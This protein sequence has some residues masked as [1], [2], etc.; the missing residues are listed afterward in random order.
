MFYF[1]KEFVKGIVLRGVDTDLT[2]NIEGSIFYNKTD[3]KFRAYINNSVQDLL[4]SGSG[5]GG[6]VNTDLSNLTSPTAIPSGVNLTSNA[7][8]VTS[9]S[10]N[11]KNTTSTKSADI[12]I[13]SGDTTSGNSGSVILAAGTTTTGQRGSISVAGSNISISTPPLLNALT[14]G[15]LGTAAGKDFIVRPE[16][17]NASQ[18]YI[19]AQMGNIFNN[20]PIPSLWVGARN[21]PNGNSNIGQ[22]WT[23]NGSGGL[24]SFRGSSV[25]ATVDGDFKGSDVSLRTFADDALN[26]TAT[27]YQ[28]SS[29]DLFIESSNGAVKGTGANANSGNIT[30]RTG[31][32]VGSGARGVVNIQAAYL[33]MEGSEIYN[34]FALNFGNPSVNGTFRI[35]SNGTNLISER[36]E[37]GIWIF[38]QIIG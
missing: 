25:L 1:L 37:G 12:I 16:S 6:G 19:H 24:L 17:G 5:G 2:D 33:S 30:I 28:M 11:T 14:I 15:E 9:F 13:K 27:N 20:E 31:L 35:R 36:R 4:T 26:S 10:V 8:D 22:L 21:P 29:G 18:N 23:E 7:Q 32:P 3:K 34:V 38:K